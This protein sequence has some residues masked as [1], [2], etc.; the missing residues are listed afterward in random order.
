MIFRRGLSEIQRC[1]RRFEVTGSRISR[2]ET[3]RVANTLQLVMERLLQSIVGLCFLSR[4]KPRTTGDTEG[5]KNNWMDSLWFLE[6][7]RVKGT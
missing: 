6:K 5:M 4:G 7:M 1:G 3:V 2:Q